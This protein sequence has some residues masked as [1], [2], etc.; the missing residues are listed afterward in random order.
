[1]EVSLVRMR[2]RN[3]KSRRSFK[4]YAVTHYAVDEALVVLWLVLDVDQVVP[5]DEAQQTA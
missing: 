4:R 5:Y 3:F 2:A 1:M